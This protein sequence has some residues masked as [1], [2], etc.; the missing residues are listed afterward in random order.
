MQPVYPQGDTDLTFV[1]V[2]QA[3]N[4]KQTIA[5]RVSISVTMIKLMAIKVLPHFPIEVGL[6]TPP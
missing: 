2:N 4:G 6:W 3:V 5:C 1:Q